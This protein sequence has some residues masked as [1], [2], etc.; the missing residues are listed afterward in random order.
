MRS[1][2]WAARCVA[3]ARPMVYPTKSDCSGGRGGF[4]FRVYGGRRG[5]VGCIEGIM[6][7]LVGCYVRL[8]GS[9]RKC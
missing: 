5:V 4:R 2:G 3:E 6:V 9:P 1:R 8:S 7:L